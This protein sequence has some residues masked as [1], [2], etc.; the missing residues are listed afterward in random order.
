MAKRHDEAAA[1][2]RLTEQ[3]GAWRQSRAK[4][5][6]MPEPLWAEAVALARQLGVNTVRNALG[7]NYG[8]LRERVERKAGR[9]VPASFVELSGA[10][11]LGAAPAATGAVVEVADTDGAR[12]TV[13]LDAGTVLDVARLVEAFRGRRG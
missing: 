2:A 8:A 4:A 10:Q 1:L 3:V 13:R 12:L 5:G 9:A 6:R 7:L 11:V